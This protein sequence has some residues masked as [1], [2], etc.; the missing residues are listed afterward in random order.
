MMI[1]DWEIVDSYIG[2]V[3]LNKE[4]NKMEAIKK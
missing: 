4:E 3:C 1:E 2:I